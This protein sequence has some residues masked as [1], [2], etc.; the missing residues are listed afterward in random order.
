[1]LDKQREIQRDKQRKGVKET[2]HK[3][4]QTRR[5]VLEEERDRGSGQ[6]VPRLCSLFTV[7]V[8]AALRPT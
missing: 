8:C 1:M 6:T 7:R 5:E 3:G 4:K 2:E